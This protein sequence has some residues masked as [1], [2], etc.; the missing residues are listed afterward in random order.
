VNLVSLISG[1][2]SGDLP[3]RLMVVKPWEAS[4]STYLTMIPANCICKDVNVT[5][6]E[7]LNNKH[8]IEWWDGISKSDL[9]GKS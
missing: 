5:D 3:N 8:S 7:I 4:L 9:C 1:F 6:F 2:V